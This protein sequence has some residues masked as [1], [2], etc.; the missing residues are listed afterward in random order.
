M[1]TNLPT[2]AGRPREHRS[3]HDKR[4]TS[5]HHDEL[6]SIRQF[7]NNAYAKPCAALNVL[8]ESVLG[9]ESLTSRFENIA[10][11]GHS[12]DL[13]R[14]TSSA[15]WKMPLVSTWIGSGAVGS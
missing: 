15:V 11:D 3:V 10:T 2:P 4:K 14:R 6:E 7:G 1:V 12:V 5:S 8:R 9:R 13:S